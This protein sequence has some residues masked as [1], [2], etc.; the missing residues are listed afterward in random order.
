MDDLPRLAS[1]L[2]S[3]NTVDERLAQ[4]IGRTA[5][6]NHV[7]E[8]I[9]AQV[10][11]IQLEDAGKQRGYDGRFTLGPLAGRTVD[12][13]WRPRRDNQMNLKPELL[14]DYFLIFTGPEAPISALATPWLIS[15]IFLF[16]AQDLLTALRERGVQLGNGTSVTGPLWERAELYPVPRNPRLPLDEEQRKLLILF[17]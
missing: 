5:Q 1:L 13:Q 16:Q 14:P 8:Y 4:H 17:S 6:V 11:H 9:A 10:F 2:K 12:I 15:S 7:G 3:R